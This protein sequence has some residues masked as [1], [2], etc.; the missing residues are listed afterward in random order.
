[1][2]V[3]CISYILW[4]VCY[5]YNILYLCLC[6]ILWWMFLGVFVVCCFSSLPPFPH[7]ATNLS[8][9]LYPVASSRLCAYPVGHKYICSVLY[10]AATGLS[11]G[12]FYPG[13]HSSAVVYFTPTA[14]SLS[15]VYFFSPLATSLSVCSGTA[16]ARRP[17]NGR[18]RQTLCSV[19]FENR[20]S[21]SPL[22]MPVVHAPLKVSGFGR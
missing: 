10:P 18:R 15:S 17:P 14:T 4:T 20:G 2:P 3:D 13:G 5:I 12:Y 21:F 19:D 8:R 6:F 1:M 9:A 11:V 7:L 16:L 22:T